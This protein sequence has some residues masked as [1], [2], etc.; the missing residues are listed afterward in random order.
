[1]VGQTCSIGGAVKAAG[2]AVKGAGGAVERVGGAVKEAG[3]AVKE[4]GGAVKE[5][6]GAVKGAGQKTTE[7]KISVASDKN[8]TVCARLKPLK[9]AKSKGAITSLQGK[10]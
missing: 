3:G 10:N 5:A 6:G 4:A 8:R 9:A 2:G 1:M 7:D